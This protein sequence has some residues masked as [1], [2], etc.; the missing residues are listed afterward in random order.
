MQENQ[1]V[2]LSIGEFAALHHIN[3]KTLMW[4]DQVGLFKPAAVGENGYRYYTYH[5][6]AALEMILMLREMDVAI[7]EIRAFMESRS[8]PAL[9]LLLGETIDELDRTMQRLETLR[10]KL[11]AYRTD[12]RMLLET[13]LEEIRLVEIPERRWLAEIPA[14]DSATYEQNSARVM[15][16]AE[17]HQV[18][19]LHNAAY[20]VMIP[21]ENLYAGKL[22]DYS[23]I[24]VKTPEPVST[25][26]L[27]LRPAGL[28]LRAYCRG[29]WEKLPERY[30]EI[31][32]Y[33]AAHDLELQG[34][35][36]EEGVNE[37]MIQRMDDYITQIEIPVVRRQTE[38][39]EE[40]R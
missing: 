40:M 28:Y 19:R 36:Y 38:N 18:D 1:K 15:A 29:T 26:G 7:P 16:E 11:T 37:L 25:E 24:F 8:A 32:A 3:K 17:R 23:A 2:L 22:E 20:G 13:D 34:C 35:A 12:V 6:S 33:A 31:L 14:D 10:E 27:H 5:Q 39:M 9:E 30:R 4:Y 21:V